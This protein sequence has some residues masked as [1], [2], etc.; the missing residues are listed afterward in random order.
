MSSVAQVLGQQHPTLVSINASGTGSGNRRSGDFGRY[1][2]T[3]NGRFVIFYSEATDIV[4]LGAIGAADVFVRDLL[5]GKTAMASINHLGTPS[6][7]VSP[8]G[9]ISDD[10]RYVAFTS[11][12]NNVTSNDTNSSPDVFIRDMH[13][14][15]TRLVSVNAAGT[16]SAAL[17]PSELIDMTPDGRFVT[18]TSLAQ[19]LTAHP[20]KNGFGSD[21]YVRDTVNNVTKLVTVNAA[22]DGTGNGTSF[23]GSISADGRYV[24]FTSESS[25][26]IANDTPTRDV[27]LR[28]MQAGTTIRLSTNAAGTGGGNNHSAGAVIDRGGRFVVF[29]TRAT[30]LSTIPDNNNLSEIFIYDIQ[31]GTKRLITVNTAGTSTG[32][33]IAFFDSDRGV[34]YNISADARYVVFATQSGNLVANDTNGPGEDVFRYEIATHTKTLVSVN[35]SGTTG[36]IGGSVNPSVSADGRYVAFNSLA[37]DLVNFPDETTGGS[38]DV[39]VR[40]MQTGQTLLLSPNAAAT[41]TGNG[42]SFQPLITA[43]GN[44][45][46]FFSRASN[47]ITND[48][49]GFEE[50]IFL[51]T[52]ANTNN[53][54][55]LLLEDDTQRA[56]ALESVTKLRGPFTL[57]P[58]VNFNSDGRTRVSLFVWRLDLLPSDN[59]SSLTALAQDAQGTVHALPVE[60]IGP[61]AGAD[62]VTQVV[63]KLPQVAPGNLSVTISLRGATTNSALVQVVAP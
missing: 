29:D 34:Q 38:H 62:Q 1:R 58:R 23:G 5:T 2:I 6:S 16:V 30:D 49:N 33:G 25:D 22:G 8:F 17:G 51:F 45:V 18:F 3:P 19:D 40:D 47:L 55:V 52:R 46:V 43:D 9:L 4:Q 41:R 54:P 39:F 21:I 14:G 13:A 24:V 35:V 26:L 7:G 42:F 15:V 11:F 32:N 60:Y 20:D 61:L 53:G 50:D 37:N 63:V 10:G 12:A 59:A 56:I 36:S 28:D 44:R 31:A 27:Y 57:A 48:L